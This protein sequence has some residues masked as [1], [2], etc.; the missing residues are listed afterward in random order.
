M[1][2]TLATFLCVLQLGVG[3][4]AL[5][6]ATPC[7]NQR[8]I[9]NYSK[10][11]RC[12]PVDDPTTCHHVWDVPV[13]T[14]GYAEGSCLFKFNGAIETDINF[15]TATN[16]GQVGPGYCTAGGASCTA[17]TPTGA[18]CQYSGPWYVGQSCTAKIDD[19]QTLVCP[20][21]GQ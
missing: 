21:S 2:S 9:I 19:P 1:K 7:T 15:T 14:Y 5:K 16:C 8:G 4:A 3:V 11:T 20:C 17:T 10:G 13:Q 12:L 18:K 6:A